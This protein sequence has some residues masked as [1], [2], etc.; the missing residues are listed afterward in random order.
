MRI[1]S[2]NVSGLRAI[3]NKGFMGFVKKENPDIICLQETKVD[4]K[5]QINIQIQL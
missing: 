1:I 5:F 3:L 4:E 2:W